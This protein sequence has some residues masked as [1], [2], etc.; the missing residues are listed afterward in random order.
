MVGCEADP[1]DV[2]V[3]T[4]TVMVD[5]DTEPDTEADTE[6]DTEAD[7]EPDTDSDTEPDTDADTDSDTA[8]PLCLAEDA[9]I[10]YRDADLDGY[11]VFGNELIVCEMQDGY[12]LD[13]GDCNDDSEDISPDA[14]EVCDTVD[15]DCNGLV[16][17]AASDWVTVYL[18]AD[19]DDFGDAERPWTGCFPT[20]DYVADAT[21]CNDLDAFVH[22]GAVELCDGVSNAC[23]DEL[24]AD[25]LD[26]DQDGVSVCAGDCNDGRQDISPQLAERC[27]GEDTNCDGRTDEAGAVDAP[28][29]HLDGDGDGFGGI[30]VLQTCYAP[31]GWVEDG[32]DCNDSVAWL[33]VDCDVPS[34]EVCPDGAECDDATECV[35]GVC[36]ETCQEPTCEDGV[37][38][39]SETDVDCGGDC[40]GCQLLEQCDESTDCVSGACTGGVCS[41]NGDLSC[42]D[43]NDCT[44]DYC[45]PVSGE[46]VYLNNDDSCSDDDICTDRHQCVQG[47]CAVLERDCEDNSTCTLDTCN[48]LL[49]I[50]EH[51]TDPSYLEGSFEFD[52]TISNGCLK[53]G[54]T[55]EY[56]HDGDTVYRVF[57][58]PGM[59]GQGAPEGWTVVNNCTQ[60]PT[61]NPNSLG[62]W[63]SLFRKNCP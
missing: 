45:S 42:D 55:G 1:I 13:A 62:Y 20:D 27:D 49:G 14:D 48:P 23:A 8:E 17:D 59:V 25:E 38:N 22:P 24:E 18:D 21:D 51:E 29:W 12:A 37:L 4:D 54:L 2:D 28:T 26:V 53:I 56:I 61:F 41:C 31:E 43:G 60:R 44:D 16:D 19:G 3:D 52:I 35:S 5:V 40:P 57:A 9:F 11:G 10:I 32:S 15:N 46:C 6:L 58:W 47:E 30:P 36:D 33:N 7:T 34:C 50:C 39:G 63:P